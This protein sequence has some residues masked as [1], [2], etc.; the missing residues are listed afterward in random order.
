MFEYW[1]NDLE[2][3]G[4]MNHKYIHSWDKYNEKLLPAKEKLFSKLE[5]K[6]ISDRD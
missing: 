1:Q 5:L 2:K 6:G 3:K 4:V